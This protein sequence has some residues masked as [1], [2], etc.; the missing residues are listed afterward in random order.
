MQY[1]AAVIGAGPA[2]S[3]VARLLAKW[4]YSVVIVA[5]QR[6]LPERAETLPPS[7][8]R[9]FRLLEIQ[10]AIEGAGFYQTTGNTSWWESSGA[11]VETYPDE[12][13]YQVLRGDF[14]RLLLSLARAA[15]VTVVCDS[16]RD[17][18]LRDDAVVK[19]RSGAEV[20]ARFAIDASGRAGVLARRGL[21]RYEATYRTIAI[22]GYWRRAENLSDATHTLIESYADGWA[23]S[24]PV[25]ASLRFV[26]LM[27]DSRAIGGQ[28][29]PATYRAEL[30]KTRVFRAFVQDAELDG[31]PWA[32]D[33]SL[34]HA[35]TYAGTQ[36]LLAGDAG[37]FIDPLSSYGVK[38]AMSSAWLAATVVNTC[39]RHPDLNAIAIEYFNSRERQ[40]YA[41][42]LRQTA[43]YFRE[44]SSYQEHPFWTARS[45]AP[46]D[47]SFYTEPELL[48]ALD[49]L[50][51]S[52]SI[53][54]RRATGVRVAPA[55]RIVGREIVVGD[56]LMAPGVPDGLEYLQGV[57]LWKLAEMAERHTQ[58]PDL[59]GAYNR[60][61]APVAL[62]NFLSALS[63]LVAKQVLTNEGAA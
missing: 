35:A 34:Y 6:R 37:S 27:M 38:K 45:G 29:V 1:D 7:S 4:G 49:E 62:P 19:L 41:D 30:A 51:G 31:R 13:G 33:A 40:V 32:C 22:C 24:V 52:A 63:L 15:G 3:T 48:R 39:L 60:V 8:R 21:R 53:R 57:H 9:L 55:P 5:P 47:T 10:N 16:V 56:G 17:V 12:P 42:Q 46:G 23:W 44:V 14:D 25:S 20:R 36:Y 18:D 50:K 59:Y 26:T 43:A 2:G 61:H 28:G 58:V 54:L 11:R